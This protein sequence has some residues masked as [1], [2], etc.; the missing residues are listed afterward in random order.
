[1][2]KKSIVLTGLSVIVIAA[3]LT[4]CG[5]IPIKP[6]EKNFETPTVTLS[7][8]DVAHYFGWWYYTPKVEPTKGKAGH[9][10]APLDYAFVFDIHNPPA[11]TTAFLAVKVFFA[12]PDIRA[13]G[14]QRLACTT[15]Y[16]LCHL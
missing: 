14:L 5:G 12:M 10:A 2:R 9:N 11:S 7:F 16:I 8:V 13:V 4:G 6:T 15:M 1:M 3:L